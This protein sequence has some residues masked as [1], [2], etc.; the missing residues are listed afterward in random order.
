MFEQLRS[1]LRRR[2]RNQAPPQA[3]TAPAPRNAVRRRTSWSV[4]WMPGRGWSFASSPIRKTDVQQQ[5][6]RQAAIDK[7][8]AA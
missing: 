3:E 8:A 4:A 5:R 2:D 1:L 7:R 6:E